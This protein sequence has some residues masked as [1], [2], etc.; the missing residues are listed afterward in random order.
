MAGELMQPGTHRLVAYSTVFSE[1]C[2]TIFNSIAQL[3]TE[4]QQK[5]NWF[6]HN[7]PKKL[8]HG[9]RRENPPDA[10]WIFCYSISSASLIA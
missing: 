3:I 9:T 2:K 10:I 6:S 7:R 8:R 4:I 5:V 1:V